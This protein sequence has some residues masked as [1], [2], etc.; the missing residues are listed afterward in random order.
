MKKHYTCKDCGAS[1]PTLA[2]S[3]YEGSIEHPAR[4]DRGM[5]IFKTVRDKETGELKEKQVMVESKIR[6]L[7]TWTC[8][9]STCKG[10]KVKVDVSFAY[11]PV[12]TAEQEKDD[13]LVDLY[14]ATITSPLKQMEASNVT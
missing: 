5:P 9:S 6:G 4:D 2:L 10:K 11:K 13:A 7:G 1:F 12:I 3:R 8:M 14:R